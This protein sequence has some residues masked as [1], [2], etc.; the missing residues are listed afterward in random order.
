M[1]DLQK[2]VALRLSPNSKLEKQNKTH[3]LLWTDSGPEFFQLKSNQPGHEECEG[4]ANGKL[5][6][7]RNMFWR[8]SVLVHQSIISSWEIKRQYWELIRNCL[9]ITAGFLQ[10]ATKFILLTDT[11]NSFS[12]LIPIHGD[13]LTTEVIDK[14]GISKLPS[15]QHVSE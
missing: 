8:I 13:S 14:T 3:I 5:S 1:V 12:W 15:N 10:H 4:Q 2:H 11:Q 6:K 7:G 9:L